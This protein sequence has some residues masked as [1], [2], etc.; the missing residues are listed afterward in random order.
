VADRHL[1]SR[2]RRTSTST[3]KASSCCI[4]PTRTPM[5]TPSSTSA[6]PM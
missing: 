1:H 2:R 6:N 4:S 5:A 3:V